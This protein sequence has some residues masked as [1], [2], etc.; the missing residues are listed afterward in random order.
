MHLHVHIGYPY[1]VESCF[2]K[3]GCTSR[4]LRGSTKRSFLPLWSPLTKFY[5]HLR[6]SHTG[7]YVY[8]GR[9]ALISFTTPFCLTSFQIE[10]RYADGR[11]AKAR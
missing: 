5:S 3:I 2:T 11:L 6:G 7:T 8:T 10:Y 1:I 4:V 9:E